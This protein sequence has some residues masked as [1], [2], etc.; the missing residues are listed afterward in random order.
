VAKGHRIDREEFR[1]LLQRFYRLRGWDENG[2]VPPGRVK[3]L[4][5]PWECA[6]EAVQ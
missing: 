3:E 2:V 6:R 1:N 5:R 4:A